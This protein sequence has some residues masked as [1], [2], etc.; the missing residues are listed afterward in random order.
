MKALTYNQLTNEQKKTV[1]EENK[2]LGLNFSLKK[3]IRDCRFIFD[4][5][6]KITRFLDT[7]AWS[8]LR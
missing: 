4:D 1:A 3:L 2:E 6:G 5:N 8:D 7:D